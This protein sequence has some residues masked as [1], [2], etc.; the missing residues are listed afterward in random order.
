MDTKEYKKKLIRG[1]IIGM[2]SGVA[3]T[4]GINTVLDSHNMIVINNQNTQTSEL[5]EDI[6]L[7]KDMD[8]TCNVYTPFNLQDEV[9]KDFQFD[10][11]EKKENTINNENTSKSAD[12]SDNVYKALTVMLGGIGGLTLGRR[13][14]EMH[15]YDKQQR[16]EKDKD[17][18]DKEA[19]KE[20]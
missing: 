20:L 17:A 3:I 16:Q 10:V 9:E 4:S 11:F 12:S 8:S 15:E 5:T 14:A 6:N 7:L 2:L 18:E 19:E 13:F 1:A